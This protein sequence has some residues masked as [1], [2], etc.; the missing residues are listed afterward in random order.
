MLVLP[1][2]AAE[3]V[4]SADG[5]PGEAVRVSDRFGQRLQRPDV[6]DPLMRQVRM[7]IRTPVSVTVSTK[8]AASSAWAWERRKSAQAV[9][10]LLG[11]GSIPASRRISQCRGAS[12]PVTEMNQ[13]SHRLDPAHR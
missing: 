3:T 2:D 1:Q 7:Y 5:Q 6:R 11:A 8:S 4:A 9:A 13:S 12:A 10:A